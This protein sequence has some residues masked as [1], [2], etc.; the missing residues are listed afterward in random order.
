MFEIRQDDLSGKEVRALIALHLSGMHSSSPPEYAFALD[1]SGLKVPEITAWS[2][3]DGSTLVGMGALK[4]LDDG[5]GEIKSM[6]T[7]PK[8][9]RRG[10]ASTLLKHIIAEARRRG[11]R[12]L[13]LETGSGSVFEPALLLYRKHGFAYGEAFAN[14]V[15]SQFNQFMHLDLAP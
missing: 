8:H 11:Y 14:Y 2:I 7:E 1:L 3:W 9:L 15:S 4:A 6:R 5:S 13:S 12:R 10:V